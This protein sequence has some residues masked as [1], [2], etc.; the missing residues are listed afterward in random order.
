MASRDGV[1]RVYCQTRRHSEAV[2]P[3]Q[4]RQQSVTEACPARAATKTCQLC[5]A[6]HQRIP[7]GRAVGVWTITD[8]N[9]SFGAGPSCLATPGSVPRR[10]LAFAW[11]LNAGGPPRPST[12]DYFL[13]SR[14]NRYAAGSRRGRGYDGRPAPQLGWGGTGMNAITK[15]PKSAA[16]KATT[17]EITAKRVVKFAIAAANDVAVDLFR[18]PES[19]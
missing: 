8:R 15:N 19:P 13:P 4:S 17:A 14:P 7:R 18:R 2:R 11:S 10:T 9:V 1:T 16:M 5:H 3:Q 12:G 6:R